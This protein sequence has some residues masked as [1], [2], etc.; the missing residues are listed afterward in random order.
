MEDQF[1]N[2]YK[3]IFILDVNFS[4]IVNLF[5]VTKTKIN[6]QFIIFFFDYDEE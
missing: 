2:T 1:E 5:E 4:L 6:N 3:G